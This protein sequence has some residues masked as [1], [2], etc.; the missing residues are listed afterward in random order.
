MSYEM[1]LAQRY[2]GVHSRLW[3]GKA[4]PLRA[5]PDPSVSEP[6]R[7]AEPAPLEPETLYSVPWFLPVTVNN[8][9]YG[10]VDEAPQSESV[11]AFRSRAIIA[12]V[13]QKYRLSKTTI[14]SHRRSRYIIQARYEAM[15]RMKEETT[16]S[17]PQI[18]RIMGGFDH[19]TVLHGCRR[20]EE[21]LASG[22]VEAA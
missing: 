17:L 8:L 16:L 9:T 10:D 20:Y 3:N 5:E 22:K 19:T 14:R 11:K 18:G 6:V 21:W 4:Q 1:E 13:C 7:E 12:Q 15:W 2:A